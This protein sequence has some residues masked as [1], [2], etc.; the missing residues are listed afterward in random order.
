MILKS[1][2]QITEQDLQSLIDNA[3]TEGKTIEY[4]QELPG[5]SDADKKEFLADVSSFANAGAGDI[6]YGIIEDKGA[7]KTLP[8]MKID[9]IDQTKTRIDSIIRE[10]IDP[11]LP[12]FTI[13]DI[14][15]ANS[16]RALIIRIGK[17][18]ISPHRVIFK[19]HNEFYSRGTNGKYRL[20]V[21]ELRI[22]FTLSET[23]IDRVKKFREERI[24]R[25]YANETPISFDGNTKIILHLLPLI[26][27]NPGQGY[28]I[29]RIKISD[30]P[31]IYFRGG[32]S[33][34]NLDGYLT[35]T[36]NNAVKS[37]SYTQLYRSGIIEAVDG[38]ILRPQKNN[39]LLIPSVGYEQELIAA[40]SAYVK[41]LKMLEVELPVLIFLTLVDVKGYIMVIDNYRFGFPDSYPIDRDVLML[42]EVLITNYN[43]RAD[44][45][46]R[47]CFDAVWNACGF[48]RSLNY[49]KD[50][51]WQE[52]R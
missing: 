25:L 44:E 1:I 28:G 51:V 48:A 40:L 13:R 26:S 29:E 19:G 10:G 34:Y 43:T 42:P 37:Y 2:D 20:D 17:S 21:G 41:V 27:F 22:A 38:F 23:I 16:N 3:V 18:W 4:K 24:A 30:L 8:G 39:D 33:R 36:G 5:S 7:A 11:R 6:I 14:A 12:S 45:A 52:K 49:D 32:S 47:P 46:L 31:T 35:Y 50:G 15:L 9:D